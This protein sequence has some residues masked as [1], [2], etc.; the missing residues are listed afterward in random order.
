MVKEFVDRVFNGAAEPLLLHLMEEEKLTTKD[1][2]DIRRTI[3][4]G[5][6]TS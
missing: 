3:R 1:L 4:K 5:K 2:E 6:K